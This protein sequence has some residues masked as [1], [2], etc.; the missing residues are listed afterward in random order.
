MERKYIVIFKKYIY[1]IIFLYKQLFCQ[2]KRIIRENI[3]LIEKILK[4]ACYMYTFTIY[5]VIR[6]H[7]HFLFL[8]H[9]LTFGHKR[10]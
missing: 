9:S 2:W 10:P 7:L 8:V 4:C 5:T 1:K 3:I 6:I